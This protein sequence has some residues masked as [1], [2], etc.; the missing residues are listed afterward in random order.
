[1]RT[2]SLIAVCVTTGALLAACGN[3]SNSNSATSAAAQAVSGREATFLPFSQCMRAHGVSNFP[4]LTHGLQIQQ[5]PGSTSVNGVTV[6]SPAFR[7][8]MQT[9]RSKLPNGGN[10]PP[11]SAARRQQALKF[12]QCMRAHG[13]TNFPDPTFSSHGAGIS[14]SAGSGINPNS[15]AFKAAQSACGSL[16]GKADVAKAP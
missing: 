3:S 4:D 11:L 1:M 12:S 16:I 6:N 5:T 2:T 15:P 8:A 9:C 10:A 14:L 13:I 7:S